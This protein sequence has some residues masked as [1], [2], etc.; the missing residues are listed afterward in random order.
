[1]TDIEQRIADA[2][3]KAM[4]RHN[5]KQAHA[6]LTDIRNQMKGMRALDYGDGFLDARLANI[7]VNEIEPLMWKIETAIRDGQEDK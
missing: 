6:R 7:I 4:Q 2:T 3:N 1:V 5:L